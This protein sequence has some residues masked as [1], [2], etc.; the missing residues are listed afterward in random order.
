M[1]LTNMIQLT[2]NSIF[3]FIVQLGLFCLV[4]ILWKRVKHVNESF[5]RWIGIKKPVF[6]GRVLHLISL[7]VVWYICYTSSFYTISFSIGSYRGNT[8]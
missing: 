5:F 7:V 1:E 4:P 3:G 6:N 8:I 2:L